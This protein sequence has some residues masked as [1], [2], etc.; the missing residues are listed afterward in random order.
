MIE[1]GRRQADAT[2]ALMAPAGLVPRVVT[3][4]EIG[5]VAVVGN[6]SRS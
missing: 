4:P 1:T 6:H 3:D 2:A 5:A